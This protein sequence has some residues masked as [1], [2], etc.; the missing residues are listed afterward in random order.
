MN[1]DD[2][3]GELP[4]YV[5]WADVSGVSFFPAISSQS[6]G[7]CFLV[8]SLEVMESRLMIRTDR[9]INIR[10]SNAQQKDCNF[11]AEGCEGGLPIQVAKFGQEFQFVESDCYD[12]LRS[13]NDD[14]CVNDISS[15]ECQ[16]FRVADYYLIGGNYGGV[17]EELIMKELL[18]NGPTTGVLNVP[19]YFSQYKGCILTQDCD[20]L[21][22]EIDYIE[23]GNIISRLSQTTTEQGHVINSR[24]LRQRGIDWEMVNHSIVIVGYGTDTE[25]LNQPSEFESRIQNKLNSRILIQQDNPEECAR[26][27]AYW[28]IANSW[29]LDFGEEG[30]VRIRRG[31][32]DFG[33]ETQAMSI[34]PDLI[35]DQLHCKFRTDDQAC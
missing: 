35:Q 26:D 4:Q 23:D 7:D 22:G 19:S 32:N 34:I 29:G 31:C 5:N 9:Q 33:I 15:D 30:F 13:Q 10:V 12:E 27:G 21:P 2:I 1:P 14:R 16:V 25:C 28:I 17:S 8:A 6:C 24:S 18:A 20:S 3:E 11:Y